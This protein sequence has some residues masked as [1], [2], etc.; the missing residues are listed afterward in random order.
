MFPLL[1]KLSIGNY[2]ELSLIESVEKD[3]K[4]LGGV[5]MYHKI[6]RCD[7]YADFKIPGGLSLDFLNDYK[8]GKSQ[9]TSQFLNGNSL[10]TYYVGQKSSPIQLRI[11]NKSEEIKKK[12][13]EERWK[14]VWLSPASLQKKPQGPAQL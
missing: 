6:S 8:V 12:G 9:H 5:V 4:S 14:F 10:E 3:I 2:S 7:L 13:T 11:Y 1:L